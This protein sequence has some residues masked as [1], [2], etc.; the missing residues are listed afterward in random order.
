MTMMPLS[1]SRARRHERRAV[2][3]RPGIVLHVRDLD[4][5]GAELD[6]I[7]DYR[8]AAVDS[9]PMAWRIDGERHAEFAHPA[10][11]F[12]LLGAAALVAAD[13]VGVLGCRIDVLNRDLH[14]VE[15]TCLQ[16]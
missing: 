13:A 5:S 8:V 14:V 11:H 9:V 6:R 4:A 16:L 15:P 7:V 1:R 10:G 12:L 2:L 3:Q